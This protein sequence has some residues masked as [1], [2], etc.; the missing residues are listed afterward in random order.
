MRL[1]RSRWSLAFIIFTC[2]CEGSNLKIN[3]RKRIKVITVISHGA[4][5]IVLDEKGNHVFGIYC[6]DTGIKDSDRA[7]FYREFGSP[8]ELFVETGTPE[9]PKGLNP[10]QLVYYIKKKFPAEFKK[11]R[12]FVPLSSYVAYLLT[13]EIATDHTHTRN[14]GYIETV[15][16]SRR[17][18]SSV[19]YKMGIEKLFPGFK[20]S[21]DTYGTVTGKIAEKLGLPKDC[22]VVACGHDSSV[23]AFL[24]ENIIST[25]TWTVNMTQ[26]KTLILKPSLQQKGFLVNALSCRNNGMFCWPFS[27]ISLG[28][29]LR[30]FTNHG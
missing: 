3:C 25:G 30:A 26:G 17:G 21:F 15:S 10:L 13:G 22:I 24:S 27:T 29:L 6:Y 20:R 4:S 18:F 28:T 23:T 19:V 12:R 1:P 8:D 11:A 9:F 5:E 7:S 16:I 14:H 2:H